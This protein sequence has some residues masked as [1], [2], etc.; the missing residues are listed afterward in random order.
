MKLTL[1]L[2]ANWPPFELAAKIDTALSGVTALF[3]PSGAGKSTL[4]SAIAGF[5]PEVGKVI[6]DGRIWQGSGR[7]IPAHKRAVA[8]VFQDG[9]LFDHLNVSRN[10]DYAVRRADPEG[11][12]FGKD[13]IVDRLDLGP[14]LQKRVPNLSGGERQRVAL[15]RALLTRPKLMLMDEPMAALDRARKAQLLPLV[16]ALPREFGIPVLYV[17]HQLDEISQIA[18]SMIAMREG[19]IVGQGPTSEMIAELD[20]RT[21]GRFEAGTML[22]GIV[23][24]LRQDHSMFAIRAA[25]GLIW[26]PDTTGARLG[27]RVRVR[28]RARDVSIATGPISGVSIRN[29]L[30]GTVSKIEVD[31]GPFAEVLVDCAGSQLRARISHMAVADLKLTIGTE[32]WALVKSV[33]FDRRFS[34]PET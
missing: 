18:D 19:K 15:G 33:A 10:F 31:G 3:G 30:Q 14:L 17:S 26:M 29:Q 11:P 12:E 23:S 24:E 28:I 9:R 5:A 6:V 20:P 25:G 7:A 34:P 21:T 32:V 8:I 27:E 4:L 16:A 2:H 22:E 1:D 13:R